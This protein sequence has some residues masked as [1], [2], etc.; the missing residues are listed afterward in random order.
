MDKH[1]VISLSLKELIRPIPFKKHLLMFGK[2]IL[3]GET[4]DIARQLATL[5]FRTTNFDDSNYTFNNQ[6]IDTLGK[7]GL[8]ELSKINEPVIAD[9]TNY[10]NK[11]KEEIEAVIIEVKKITSEAVKL[12]DSLK[13]LIENRSLPEI[14]PELVT[15]FPANFSRLVSLHR[16]FQG[17][18]AYPLFSKEPSYDN[19]GKKE[20]VLRFILNKLPEPDDSVSLEKLL[21]FRKDPDTLTKYYALVKWVNEI[22]K[23][24][25]NI[26][27][28][29]DE[30]NYLYHEYVEHFRIHKIK[31]KQGILEIF[32]TASIDVLSGQLSV[33]GVSTSLFS[34]WKHNL[35]L[36]EAESNFTGREIAYIHKTEKT[37]KDL[38]HDN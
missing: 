15:S 8:L 2:L 37:F 33:G 7:E 24:D 14:I 27:E 5:L 17:F 25:F 28:I 4:L 38:Y 34:L 32:V 26:H 10:K 3:V 12:R 6:T 16:N 36:L 20:D 19:M 21:D 29:N 13:L 31:S 30:Y 11:S 9:Y 35:N 22:A 18:E 23:K 1:A